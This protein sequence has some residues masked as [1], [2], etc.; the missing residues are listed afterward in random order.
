MT[1]Q[2]ATTDTQATDQSRSTRVALLPG[3]G[4]GPDIAAATRQVLDAAGARLDLVE[5]EAGSAVFARGIGSGLPGETLDA[6]A[7]CGVALKGPLATPLGGG[8]KSANVTL[9]K[10]FE[11]H[12]NV[13]PARELPGVGG[14]FAGMGIDLIVVRENVEDLYAGIEYMQTPGVAQ[15]LK[16]ITEHG[17]EKVV[18]TGF[19]LARQQGRSSVHCATKSNILK[20]TEGMLQRVFERIAPEYPEITPHH[21]LVDNCAHQLVIDPTQ[22]EVIITTNMNGDI[23]SDLTS[24]LV[25]GL[26]L[27]PSANIGTGVAIFE[28]V[29]GT[30]PDIAGTGKANPTAMLRAA[31]LLLEHVGQVEVARAIEDAIVVTLEEGI[32]LTADIDRSG[33]A[34]STERYTE[35]V[36]AN[37]GRRSASAG[38]EARASGRP[39][40]AVVPATPGR[41]P[42]PFGSDPRAEGLEVVGADIFVHSMLPAQE[43]GSS[44]DAIVEETPLR[45]RLVS[46][47]GTKVYPDPEGTPDLVDTWRCRFVARDAGTPVGD[48][49][50]LDLLQCIG[51]QH[52]WVHVEKL[53]RIDGQEAFTAAQGEDRSA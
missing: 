36:I 25:G 10:L 51:E 32:D 46:N 45:L 15:A 48:T 3:D 38:S 40:G 24:G 23:L 16:V 35:R 20:L 27:A 42:E 13:R 50:L 12:A 43:L 17:C 31:V 21:M 53:H 52:S 14:P 6:I 47:R 34:A 41:Q 28:P 4:I 39:G 5:C 37:L 11:T 7:S 9:R 33:S 1:T 44:L 8:G 26:G 30:A 18:R 22:F 2:A 19:E 29:H 49:E